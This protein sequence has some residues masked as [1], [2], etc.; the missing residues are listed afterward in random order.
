MKVTEANFRKL[1]SPSMLAFADIV[2]GDKDLE[3]AI[4]IKG[5]RILDG[6][7]GLWVAWPDEKGK[8]GNYFP[9]VK[10]LND[11]LKDQLNTQIL[12]LYDPTPMPDLSDPF[13]AKKQGDVREEAGDEDEPF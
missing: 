4:Y 1:N 3:K 7:H 8:D 11:T 13:K 5:L 6:S 10:I 2:I 12:N 9:T